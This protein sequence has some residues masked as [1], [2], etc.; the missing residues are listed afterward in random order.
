[1]NILKSGQRSRIT[2]TSSDPWK[3]SD[4]NSSQKGIIGLES[5]VLGHEMDAEQE[6]DREFI[7]GITAT[8]RVEVKVEDVRDKEK[9]LNGRW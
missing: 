6:R 4:D 2:D 8:T 5:A 3:D 1:M 9:A 7:K